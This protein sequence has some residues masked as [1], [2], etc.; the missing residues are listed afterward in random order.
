[1]V[2]MNAGTAI[3]VRG[4]FVREKENFHEPFLI[5]GARKRTQI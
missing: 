3:N 4:I 5:A 1:M 2:D